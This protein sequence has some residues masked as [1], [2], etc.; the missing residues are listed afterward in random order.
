M[1]LD[2]AIDTILLRVE[3]I[4]SSETGEGGKLEGIKDVIIGERGG[5]AKKEP[6]IY[7]I[8]G[9]ATCD[10]TIHTITETWE[11]NIS[12]V[13]VVMMVKKPEEGIRKANSYVTKARSLLLED[14][15]L[16]LRDFVQDTISVSFQPARR[17]YSG[18][19]NLY[20][21]GVL[22]KIRFL[23]EE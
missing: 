20:G 4:I 8:P 6:C 11:F 15:S 7:I 22:M 3:E 13:S 18:N 10:H 12:L 1:F 21:A 5:V 16:G 14:R 23:I 2:D 9:E 17:A 19:N